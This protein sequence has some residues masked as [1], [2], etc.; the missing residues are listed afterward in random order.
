[1]ESQEAERD[2]REL[3]ML[4]PLSDRSERRHLG[5]PLRH[6]IVALMGVAVAAA[7]FYLLRKIGY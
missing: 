2:P 1:M 5:V 6:G 3:R 4:Q 7:S